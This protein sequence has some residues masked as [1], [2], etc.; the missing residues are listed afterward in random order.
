MNLNR[1]ALRTAIPIALLTAA[2][3]LVWAQ[4]LP[5]AGL[6]EVTS[7]MTWQQSPMPAGMPTPPNSPFAGGPRTFQSCVTQADI[8]KYGTILQQ[9]QDR[10]KD[11]QVTNVQKSGNHVTA[12]LTCSGRMAGKGTV[13]ASWTDREHSQTKMHFTGAIQM[14]PQSKTVEWTT[15][16][17][18]VFKGDD[19][20]SV[21]PAAQQ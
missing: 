3:V 5:K 11:C 20:G 16:S 15:E 12:D 13:E 2:A 19:C 9:R 21:K 10:N 1:K 14:G 7:T 4:D 6:W 18:S 8:D 17:T